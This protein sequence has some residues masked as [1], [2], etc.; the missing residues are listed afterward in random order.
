MPE[1]LGDGFQPWSF[2]RSVQGVVRVGAIDDLS[3]ENERGIT[4]ESV[5]LQDSFER[6]FLAVMAERDIL[7]IVGRGAEARRFRHHLVGGHEEVVGVIADELLDEPRRGDAVD[8]HALA[9]DP[10]HG[11]APGVRQVQRLLWSR[12]ASRRALRPCS[13][14]LWS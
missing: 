9:G 6:A 8:L 7:G 5:F 2:R 4:R 12:S 13:L 10:F 14:R 11:F 3:K 1:A